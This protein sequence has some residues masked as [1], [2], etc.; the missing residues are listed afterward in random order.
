MNKYFG[1]NTVALMS[2]IHMLAEDHNHI[3]TNLGRLGRHAEAVDSFRRAVDLQPNFPYACNNLGVALEHLGRPADAV[4]AYRRAIALDPHYAEAYNHLGNSLR[5]TGQLKEAVEAHC[6]AIAIRRD[7]PEAH[8][9]LAAAQ[10]EL[11]LLAESISGYQAVVLLQ[12]RSPSAH[13]NL[14]YTLH[15]DPSATPQALFAE[16]TRWSERHESPIRSSIA[17]HVNDHAAGRPLR[18]GYVSPDFRRHTIPHLAAPVVANHDRSEFVVFCYSAVKNADDVTLRFQQMCDTWRDISTLSDEDA[19]TLI[20]NDQIDILV[21]LTGH[22][23][24]NRLSLV[25]R[26]P[27][28]VQVQLG[29]PGTTGLRAM[30]FRI[31]DNHSDPPGIA[32]TFYTERL[33]RLPE[34]AWCY[35]PTAE[36]PAVSPPP[37][38]SRG[39]VT[40]G[41]L[42]KLIK[43]TD[44]AIEIWCRILAGLPTSKVML[45]VPSA[46]PHEQ[47]V[48]ERFCKHGV[49]GTRVELLPRRP[50]IEYLRL[51]QSIDV[52]LDP[53]PYNGDTT[54]CDSL[55]MG[56]PVVTWA[57]A[58]CVS[59]RGVSYLQNVGLG[60]LI[61]GTPEE[62]V[63]RAVDLAKDV[64]SLAMIRAGLRDRM[65]NS[66]I[67]DGSRY[68]RNLERAF[69]AMWR[70]WCDNGSLTKPT[71]NAAAIDSN[72]SAV[73]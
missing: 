57:G 30:D 9:S 36:S 33:I 41:C 40:F 60:H 26:K 61:G 46:G 24:D 39:F 28:P 17:P 29:Y 48:R 1:T 3:G 10:C 4:E 27:A 11:G 50:R 12:P 69:R 8:A 38:L 20:R 49:D 16:A 37:A 19:A 22:M 45:L 32:D 13:S 52:S 42:N 72:C 54:T 44:S 14:I 2:S 23:G 55:W 63:Q 65:A 31:T 5:A 51:F 25:A 58:S 56:V 7:Y 68:T 73:A 67:T 35:E 53:F 21:D 34:C 18:L 47:T 43:I 6:S 71:Q 64:E 66:P 62:Y 70:E 15:Y 59:R